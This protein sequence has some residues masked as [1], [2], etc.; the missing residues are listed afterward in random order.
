MVLFS[1]EEP[2]RKGSTELLSGTDVALNWRMAMRSITE[3]GLH[4][5]S[6]A[7]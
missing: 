3:Y 1:R 7:L 6:I 2:G 5:Q 4:C